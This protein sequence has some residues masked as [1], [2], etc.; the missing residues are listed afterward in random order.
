MGQDEILEWLIKH[1][2]GT[3]RQIAEGTGMRKDNVSYTVGRLERKVGIRINRKWMH[4][5]RVIYELVEW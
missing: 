3:I 5:G 4:D 1:R 2:E